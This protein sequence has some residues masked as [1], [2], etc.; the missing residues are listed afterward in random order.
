MFVHSLHD[1]YISKVFVVGAK[2]Y[3]PPFARRHLLRAART[4]TA[5]AGP[6]GQT[7]NNVHTEACSAPFAPA[8]QDEGPAKAIGPPPSLGQVEAHVQFGP[9]SRAPR[10]DP[11]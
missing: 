7:K 5:S 8:R 6:T 10:P 3:K 2:A 11:A 1:S 9:C 4:K